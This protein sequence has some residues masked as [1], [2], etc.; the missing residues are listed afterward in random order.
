MTGIA[1]NDTAKDIELSATSNI[2]LSSAAKP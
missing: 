2:M 1:K